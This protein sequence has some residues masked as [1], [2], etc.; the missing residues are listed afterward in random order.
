MFQWS[1]AIFKEQQLNMYDLKLNKSSY[2]YVIYDNIVALLLI[3][4]LSTSADYM[5]D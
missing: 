5:C 4:M 3:I 2:T 1:T